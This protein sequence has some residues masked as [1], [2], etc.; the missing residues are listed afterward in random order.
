MLKKRIK[1]EKEI[2]GQGVN[3]LEE[4]LWDLYIIQTAKG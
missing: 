4:M 2:R 1:I 3:I